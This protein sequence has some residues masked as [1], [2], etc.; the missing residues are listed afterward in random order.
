VTP[1]RSGPD[2]A[3]VDAAFAQLATWG[4]TH[5][6]A[7]V[8]PRQGTPR[9]HGDDQHVFRAASVGKLL[10]GYA[11]LV[12]VEE[13]AVGLDDPVGPPGATLRHLL[14]HAAGYGFESD[15]GV[16]AA[17]ASR[18]VY[19]NRG[20][21]VAAAHVGQATA[22]PF[23]DY[24]AEAVLDPLQMKDTELRGSPAHGLRST[25]A[26]LARFVAEIQA[27]AVLAPESVAQMRTTQFPGLAGVLPGVGRF[28]PLDWGLTFERN[29]GRAGHW[30]GRRVSPEA[31]GHFGGAGTFLWDDPDAGLG[32]VVLTDREFG[33]WALQAWP[34]WHDTLLGG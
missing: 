17:P 15:A 21:E 22:I 19:S 31:V 29:F 3:A 6:A 25:A 24:L 4:A 18:R 2:P 10:A 30:S 9:A 23:A 28:D 32:A 26:D 13:G 11:V 1:A 5:V 12:A 33:P 20:I 34:T 14:A 7:A 8:V 27:P 16:V